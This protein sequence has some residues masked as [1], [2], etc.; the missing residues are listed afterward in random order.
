MG[1]ARCGVGL[2]PE[3]EPLCPELRLAASHSLA[4]G[5]ALPRLAE[6]VPGPGSSGLASAGGRAAPTQ[7]SSEPW[8]PSAPDVPAAPTPSVSPGPP[9]LLCLAFSCVE[10]LGTGRPLCGRGGLTGLSA[11]RWRPSS[12]SRSPGLACGLAPGVGQRGP[13]RRPGA[14]PNMLRMLLSCW[15]LPGWSRQVHLAGGGG[16]GAAA[17]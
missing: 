9:E 8:P 12:A 4:G 6:V 14:I 1:D 2:P 17:P 11:A 16:V 10:G 13:S 15:P 7:G 3:A 5:G